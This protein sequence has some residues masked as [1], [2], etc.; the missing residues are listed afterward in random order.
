[1][2]LVLHGRASADIKNG[3]TLS[4]PL[5]LI[6]SDKNKTLLQFDFVV[7]NPPFSD[8]SW[9]DGIDPDNDK[10]NR[11]SKFGTP[12]EKNGDYAWF[13]HVLASLNSTGKAGIVMPHGVLFRGNT[14]ED[15]RRKILS[16]RCIKGI[17][18]LPA[19]LFY[20]TGIPACI[21]LIDKEN[22][23]GR[24]GI[25]FI[26]AGEGFRKDG[27]KNRLREQDIERIVR[28]FKAGQEI[29]GY[30]RFVPYS[31]I[32]G[33][34][35]GN[36]NVPRYIRKADDELPHDI[37][38]HLAGG[39]PQRDIESLA[40]LWEVSPE[41]KGKIF[42]GTRINPD[43]IA[44]WLLSDEYISAQRRKECG[45]FFSQW[46]E[47][48]RPMMMALTNDKVEP[49][50]LIRE[51]GEKLLNAYSESV[52]ADKFDVFDC[53][54]NYWNAK[55]Q[56]DV[57]MIKSSGWESC[58]ALDVETVKGKIRAWDGV[59]IPREVM[60]REYY[61][62]RVMELQRL[63]EESA[64]LSGELDAVREEYDGREDEE[65]PD[66]VQ[67]ELTAKGKRQKGV[68]RKI[69]ELRVELDS[70]V[71]KKY[72]ELTEGEIRHLVFDVKWMG[73]LHRQVIDE[74][75]RSFGWYT[76]R[77]EEIARRYER[78][79]VEIDE[80]VSASRELVREALGRMGYSW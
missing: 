27:S 61:P 53:L 40:K 10:Y 68:E 29:E 6:G 35:A 76:S 48:V 37:A 52:F 3:N 13:M 28:V 74:F 31:E 41:L 24:T 71:M 5:H 65:I 8:K 7:M 55:V 57:Y 2:N 77:V 36:L 38:A 60:E 4:N 25:F 80:G 30:S 66:E 19:N 42:A 43:E 14:E 47:E 79:L 44:L 32:L 49:K 67:K 22:A 70:L 26:D 46:R 18:S 50:E 15:I 9:S 20:G 62:E 17:I 78:P 75:S 63:A 69:R 64:E 51:L 21:I 16:T 73:Y 45:K 56:D 33:E 59:V 39:I 1:M 54:M 72:P 12:P 23:A 34:N 58:R 11:F